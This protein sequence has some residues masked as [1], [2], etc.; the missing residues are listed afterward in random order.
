MKIEKGI[1]VPEL[2]LGRRS[3]Y[4]LAE[5]EVGESFACEKPHRAEVNRLRQAAYRY[6]KRHGKKF[7]VRVSGDE[8][9]CWRVS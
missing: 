1:P 6:G 9:R 3:N 5:M 7:T 8:V 4:P 2:R